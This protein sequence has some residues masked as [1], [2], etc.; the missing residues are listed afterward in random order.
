MYLGA[1]VEE[2]AQK[3]AAWVTWKDQ[4]RCV[5]VCVCVNL[6]LSS[7]VCE[8][9]VEAWLMSIELD[10]W[11]DSELMLLGFISLLLTVGQSVISRICISEKVAATFHPCTHQ[12]DHKTDARRLF[13]DLFASDHHQ[14]QRRLLAAGGTDKCAAQ[15][16]IYILLCQILRNYITSKY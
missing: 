8:G 6:N 12:R 5:C 14:N 1:V 7:F 9:L 10:F 11:L 15:V 13:S 2:E 16:Y 3:S 4:I